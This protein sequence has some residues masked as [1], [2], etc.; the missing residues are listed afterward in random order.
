MVMTVTGSSPEPP[1]TPETTPQPTARDAHA[2]SAPADSMVALMLRGRREV[3]VLRL[4]VMNTHDSA[5]F[6]MLV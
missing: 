1:V 6:Q 3:G 5:T 4:P 2:T